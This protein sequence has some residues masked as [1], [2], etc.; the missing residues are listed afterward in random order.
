MIISASRVAMAL[1]IIVACGTAAAQTIPPSEMPGRE[2]ERF[3]EP[4]PPRVQPGG[5]MFSPFSPPEAI[6]TPG[7]PKR[8]HPKAHVPKT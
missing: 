8:R 4:Q 1:A 3:T 6:H 7:Y 2:R 5:S